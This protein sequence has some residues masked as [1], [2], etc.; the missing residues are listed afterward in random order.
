[1]TTLLVKSVVAQIYKA[2]K[3]SFYNVHRNRR[4]GL[5]PNAGVAAG[6]RLNFSQHMHLLKQFA[7]S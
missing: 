7:M 5:S 3:L 2:S 4:L 1:L 6:D